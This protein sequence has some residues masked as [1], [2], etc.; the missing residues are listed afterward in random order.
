MKELRRLLSNFRILNS[1]VKIPPLNI[2]KNIVEVVSKPSFQKC[3]NSITALLC[4]TYFN[5]CK[6]LPTDVYRERPC[7]EMCTQVFTVSCKNERDILILFK[8]FNLLPESFDCNWYIK[9]YNNCD[10][11]LESL[12]KRLLFMHHAKTINARKSEKS[13]LPYLFFV[14]LC[15]T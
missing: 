6:Q 15:L 2:L 10:I 3:M 12:G 5:K 1:K 8:S 11:S 7:R 4:R 9:M 14:C 13:R